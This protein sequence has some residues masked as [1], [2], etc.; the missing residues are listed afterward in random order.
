MPLTIELDTPTIT[1]ISDALSTYP[2]WEDALLAMCRAVGH[3]LCEVC[4]NAQDDGGPFVL[5]TDERSYIPC[6]ATCAEV[7]D[8]DNGTVIDGPH[9]YDPDEVSS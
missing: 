4:L 2:Q 8:E 9:V 7:W 1:A 6:C 5:A 3:P